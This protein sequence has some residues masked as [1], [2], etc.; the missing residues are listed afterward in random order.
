[1]V[2]KDLLNNLSQD[3]GQMSLSTMASH[4]I[5]YNFNN[6]VA[7]VNKN[8]LL[9]PPE[10]GASKNTAPLLCTSSPTSLA[11]AGSI[12]LVSINNDPGFTALKQK[13]TYMYHLIT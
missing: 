2:A 10:T 5:S 11:T 8:K 12:V 7:L 9:A 3:F 13:G 1:M 4:V 6:N